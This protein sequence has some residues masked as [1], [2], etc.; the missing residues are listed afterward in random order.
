MAQDDSLALQDKLDKTLVKQ[1]PSLSK[2]RKK[3]NADRYLKQSVC[4]ILPL[5]WGDFMGVGAAKVQHCVRLLEDLGY[6]QG[7]A[8]VPT[9]DIK[10]KVSRPVERITI[11]GTIT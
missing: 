3:I 11:T 4:S 9:V 5:T 7:C 2:R 8:P 1:W 6:L 10:W